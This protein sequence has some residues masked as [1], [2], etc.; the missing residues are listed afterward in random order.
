MLKNAEEC[1]RIL[2]H[3]EKYWRTLKNDENLWRSMK[4]SEEIYRILKNCFAFK[5]RQTSSL[6]TIP[7]LFQFSKC[8]FPSLFT[9]SCTLFRFSS[10]PFLIFFKSSS[11]Y[12]VSSS[13]LLQIRF[14]T[15]FGSFLVHFSKFHQ[16]LR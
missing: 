14:Q 16:N 2:K 11:Y 12:L 1:W 10:D 5:M 3:S 6:D 13:D 8:P 4:Q 9:F 15:F 7:I